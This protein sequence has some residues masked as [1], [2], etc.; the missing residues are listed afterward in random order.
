MLLPV[1]SIITNF[2][3]RGAVF[4]CVH[5]KKWEDLSNCVDLSVIIVLHSF[6]TIMV[7][8]HLEQ[9]VRPLSL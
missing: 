9:A 3:T 5:V 2:D 7:R 8:I 1:I 6:S 4:S